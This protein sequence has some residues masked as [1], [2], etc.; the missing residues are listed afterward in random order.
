M[1]THVGRHAASMLALVGAA[2]LQV[3]AA[4]QQATVYPARPVRIIL[5]FTPDRVSTLVLV[6]NPSFSASSVKQ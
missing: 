2:P 4:A 6:A 1:S 5:G 3:T